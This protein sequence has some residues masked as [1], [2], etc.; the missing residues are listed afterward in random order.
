MRVSE[1]IVEI[2]EEAGIDTVFG[3]P[4]EQMEA[5]YAAL[6][7]SGVRHVLTRNETTAAQMA[8]GYARASFSAAVCDGVGGPGACNLSA[9][10]IE[11]YGACSPVVA[12]TGDN[13]RSFRGR[14]GIQDA[15]NPGIMEP[16]TR[17]AFDPETPRRAVEAVHRAL[18]ES[19]GGVPGTTHVNLPLDV[20]EGT[21]DE[22]PRE[23][24]SVT[25]PVQ[26]PHPSPPRLNEA[27]ERLFEADRPVVIA[28]EGV[29][30]ARAWEEVGELAEAAQLPV[31]TTMNAKGAVDETAR[32]SAGVIGRW[33]FNP[34]A[35]RIVDE[36]DVLLV[37]GCRLGW[38]STNRWTLIPDGADL[39]HVDRDETWLGR[40]YDPDVSLLADVGA[41]AADLMASGVP[42]DRGKHRDRLDTIRADLREWRESKGAALAS[43]QVPVKPERIVSE[44]ARA[45][46]P[47][48][49][50]V[51]AT[52]FPG[53]FTGAFYRVRRPGI[54]YLQARGSDGI[55]HCLAQAIGVQAACPDRPVV[56]VSGDGGIGYHLS[57]LETAVRERFPV[58]VVVFNNQSLRSSKLSQQLNWEFD[59]STD[60]TPETSYAAVAEGFGCEGRMVEEPDQLANALDRGV[61]S[62][63]PVLLDVRVD[64]GALPPVQV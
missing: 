7:D 14:G 58:T 38:L 53:Y 11:P 30:R 42:D 63:H 59:L 28:G 29:L 6:A 9:G 40:N 47:E 57:E 39:I 45:T 48:T 36:A 10:L 26:R 1:R 15:D 41:A 27:A 12:L 21:V 19:V 2:F 43:D 44:I 61:A 18:R 56:A 31:V 24:R 55:N 33:G 34:P 5:Y 62:D 23:T 51:S 64:P 13:P 35:N 52:S 22:D 54:G 8:D 32:H 3:F 4:S 37:L 50:L 46:P 16:V 17:T 25:Y 20:L 60:F 49:V